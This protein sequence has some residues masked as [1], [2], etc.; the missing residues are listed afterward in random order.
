MLPKK[1]TRTLLSL[2]LTAAVS[3][4]SADRAP[5]SLS[6][7]AADGELAVVWSITHSPSS[8]VRSDGGAVS[9]EATGGYRFAEKTAASLEPPSDVLVSDVPNDNGYFLK[10]SWIPSPSEKDLLVDWYR[11]FRSRSSVLTEPVPRSRFTSLNDLIT[12]EAKVTILVDSVA[13]GG[14][15][16]TD[17]VP[18]NGVVYHY[19]IQAVGTEKPSVMGTVRDTDGNP[20]AGAL[21]RLYND[22]GTVDMETASGADG[23]F[24]FYGVPSGVYFLVAKRDGYGIF[25]TTVTV[26]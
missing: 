19:W 2:L 24:A 9:W 11:I 25:S 1:K 4:C 26:T 8:P 16:Y 5:T 6:D 17:F 15:S 22:E 21:I 23:S 18:L 14:T 12:A 3:G 20:V 7:T 10:I 13:V